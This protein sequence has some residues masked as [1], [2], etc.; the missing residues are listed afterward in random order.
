MID[1]ET[2]D[3]LVRDGKRILL[4]TQTD[5]DRFLTRLVEN[6][7]RYHEWYACIGEG[8]WLY[9]WLTRAYAEADPGIRKSPK[10]RLLHIKHLSE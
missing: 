1:D 7:P 2:M 8:D 4:P 6:D 10:I 9:S 5:Y 3:K